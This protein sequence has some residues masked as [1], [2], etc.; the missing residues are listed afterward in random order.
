MPAPASRRPA[1]TL[2]ELLVVIA[3]I[4]VLIALLV[5]AVQKVREAA[6]RTHC[7]NNLKQLGIA[8]HNYEGVFRHFPLIGQYPNPTGG[9]PWSIQ[10][11]LLPHVEQ[12]QLQN[13]IQFDKPYSHADNRPVART[14][15]PLLMCPSEINDKPVLDS[16]DNLPRYYPGNY[17]ANFGTWKIY[18][19]ATLAGG[20]G[21]FAINLKARPA[22]ITDGLSNTIGFAEVK[23]F[24]TRVTNGNTFTMSATYQVNPPDDPT[25]ISA[26]VV[27]P[28]ATPKVTAHTEWVE[29]KASQTGFTSTFAPNANVP[30]A[31]GGTTYDVNFHH[32]GEGSLT[33]STP[34]SYAA[35]TSRSFHTGGVNILLMDGSVRFVSNGVGL[36]TW[37][38]LGTRAGNDLVGDF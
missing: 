3:I 10:A 12:Q 28:A 8:L 37:R 17:A 20:D 32:V 11:L 24:G 1:F 38:A 14:R 4:A 16:V 13:L 2:I 36:A 21:G 26:L 22:H 31:S 23:A 19:P 6:A 25:L 30:H 35:I 18:D 29:G 5:P 27:D 34:L 15:V 7:Q 9:A 33:A